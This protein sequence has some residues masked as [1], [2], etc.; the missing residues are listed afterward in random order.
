MAADAGP[1]RVSASRR[2]RSWRPYVQ[3]GA[4]VVFVVLLLTTVQGRSRLPLTN[5]FFRFD[6]LVALSAMLAARSLIPTLA[7]AGVTLL[8]T[9][10]LGRVWCGWLCPFGTLLEWVRFDEA[11]RQAARL[12]ARLRLV[13]TLLLVAIIAMAALGSLTLLVL[14]PLA[15]L[16]RT[17]TVAVL[18]GVNSLVTI[19]DR[20]LYP[21]LRPVTDFVEGLL[22]GYVLPPQQTVFQQAVVVWLVFLALLALNLLAD[23][24]WCRYLC[25]LGALLA[26]LGRVALFRPV[27]GDACNG[28]GACVSA[29]RLGAIESGPAVLPDQHRL[30]AN[31]PRPVV[32]AD[33]GAAG[34][35][36]DARA[37][38]PHLD[39]AEC[40]MCLDCV[41]AC[42]TTAI[43][44]ASSLEAAPLPAAFD[45]GRRAFLGTVAAGVAGV[46]LATAGV[47]RAKPRPVLLRPPGAQTA[48]EDEFLARCLRCSECMKVCPTLGL[49]PAAGEG[50]LLSFWTPV[51]KPRQG[52][53]DY[54]C[55][56]CGRV[57]PSSAIPALSLAEKRRV[58]IGTAVID[59]RRCLPW[60]KG[61]PCIVCQ[62]M[63]PTPQKAI[64]LRTAEVTATSGRR[65]TVQ[66][67]VMVPDLCIGCGIC[68]YQCPVGGVAAIRVFS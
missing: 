9:I 68:E 36:D 17:A 66:Q 2:A 28:C 30:S 23:R 6:P 25:P 40:T 1:R 10:L 39:L 16:T 57:C 29:C 32:A 46:A 20:A 61:T 53:C 21:V 14:D 33:G 27:V 54:G 26:L 15:L 43:G 44:I 47:P 38:R 52:Y 24:F 3:I 50:G 19:V 12:P 64:T 48:G 35:R 62:E 56:S 63:C 65:V 34:G 7:L 59:R 45:P 58:V 13:K 11:R 55:N 4:F 22:R 31:E 18:P 60:A 51:L 5:L 67:P 8:V 37:T 49:Q 42:P 41:A